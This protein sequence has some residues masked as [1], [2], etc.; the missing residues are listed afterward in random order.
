MPP[1]MMRTENRN[2][3]ATIFF[4]KVASAERYRLEVSRDAGGT[5]TSVG[6][7]S[8]DSLELKG[9]PNEAKIHVRAVAINEER[10]SRPA[11]EYPVYVTG[12]PPSPP[13]G[14]K[15][16]LEPDQVKLS[17]GEILGVT[18]YRL[19][20]RAK[21]RGDFSEIF[22]G[23]VNEFVDRIKVPP[24]YDFPGFQADA[25]RVGRIPVYEYAVSAVNGNG[26][27]ARSLTAD[28]DPRSWRNWNP[29]ADL[30]FKRQSGF[31]LP[32][33]VRPEEVPPPYYP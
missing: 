9:F 6:E 31:W 12:A 17:W 8:G 33:Y 1:V 23:R 2:G 26:E 28:T 15:I 20:R 27:G 13:D 10:E 19:Y 16:K 24:A 18:E 30:R 11:D 7:T 22:R 29:T 5:W 25:L 32:P 4:T 3:G 14:L 21:G